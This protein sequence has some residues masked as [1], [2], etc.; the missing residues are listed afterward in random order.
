MRPQR[1]LLTI[2]AVASATLWVY[3]CG[4][5][6]TEPP[7]PDPLLPT[8]VTVSPATATVVEGDTLRL[9]A[10]ATNV[11]GQAVTG[12]EFVWASGNAAVAVVDTTGLVTGVAAGQVQVTAT[13]AGLT[14][15]AELAVVTPLPTTVAVTP[16]TVV[17]T[18]VGQTAQLTAE[19]RDQAGR[20]MEG[21]PVA[22]LS[23]E[24][25][26]AGVDASGLVTAVG[27]G[28]VTI[29]ATAGEA[30]GD[31]LVT[32]EID[33]DRAALVA[34]YNA[35]DGP[36][37]VDNTNWLTDAPLGEWYGVDT[38]ASGRVV[39][40][41]LS[42]RW[43]NEAQEAVRHGLKGEIPA[44][45]GGLAELQ[46]LYLDRNELTGGIPPELGGLANLQRLILGN[47]Q[48]TGEIPPELGELTNLRALGLPINSL[49]GE[50]PA[51]IGNLANLEHLN[52]S[53]GG[54]SGKIPAEIG[55][56]R[57]AA[58]AIRQR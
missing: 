29:T 36:N 6:T 32:V 5:G 40:L 7:A 19:V 50:I 46:G 42:G 52:L 26:V 21:V 3:A 41:G 47:N 57:Q 18:A 10:T 12:V 11:H 31:A 1:L 34:L 9:T 45:L 35:T 44:E 28:A 48:L 23:A 53:R 13:A 37:W 17:L 55:N 27:G 4:D 24:T 39:R 58:L 22:W 43:D 49:T 33:L 30:S 38:D 20:V 14:G 54:L 16:D 25:T 51:E 56:H 2:S 15:R 8:T